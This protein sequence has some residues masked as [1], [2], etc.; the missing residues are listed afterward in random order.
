MMLLKGRR[1]IIIVMKIY[2][3]V[4]LHRNKGTIYFRLTNKDKEIIIPFIQFSLK[5][6]CIKPTVVSMNNGNT[7]AGTWLM[8][9][10]GVVS[11]INLEEKYNLVLEDNN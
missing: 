1:G 7:V 11:N 6:M 8:F 5:N 3:N 10:F 2:K 9:T 4:K